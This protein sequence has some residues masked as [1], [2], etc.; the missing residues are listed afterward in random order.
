MEYDRDKIDFL[1]E[2]MDKTDSK[3]AKYRQVRQKMQQ[4]FVDLY[5][6]FGFDRPEGGTGYLTCY[7][8]L[9]S[10]AISSKRLRPAVLVIPGGGY[11][12]VSPREGEPVAL[13]FLARGYSAFVLEYS[14]TSN[15]FPV[16][17]QEAA[18]A[19]CYIRQHATEFELDPGMVTAIG[20]SA[21][22]HLCGTLGMLYDAP[23]VAHIG[24]AAQIRPDALGLCYPVAVSWGATHEGSFI[25][26]CGSDE[27]L[28]ERLSLDRLA[29]PDMP[30]VYLWHTRDDDCV[31]VRNSL[32][33]AN[34]MEA[35]G[36]D[37][38]MRLYRHGWHG[39][40]TAD[41]QVYPVSVVP[42][43]SPDVPG[44]LEEMLGFFCEI[45][46]KIKDMEQNL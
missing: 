16:Q 13:R 44:W 33:L 15:R 11:E 40:S 27:A 24:T 20:F 10:Q 3:N 4:K 14:V 29:R 7:I 21:G 38:A 17:L 22:G 46:I 5:E 18:M 19:M 23:E 1:T 41:A 39:L 34:A 9:T 37:F 25:N 31:P 26:L 36:V 43:M 35:A 32:L 6:Y 42:G 28:R 2:Q 30:P 8:Q 45:G 12:H